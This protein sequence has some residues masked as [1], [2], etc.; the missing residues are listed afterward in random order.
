[1]GGVQKVAA[2][3]S[4]PTAIGSAGLAGFTTGRSGVWF[5]DFLVVAP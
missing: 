3:D 1:V 4:A 2:T 5:D